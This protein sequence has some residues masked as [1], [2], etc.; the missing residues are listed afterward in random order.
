MLKIVVPPAEYWNEETEEFQYEGKETVLQLE[1]SLVSIHK[2]ESK[3]HKPFLSKNPPKTMEETID[4]VKFMTINSN[5]PDEIFMRLSNANLTQIAKYIEDPMTATWFSGK[6]KGSKRVVT[7]EIIYSQMIA[8]GIPF[9]CRKWH[10]NSLLTLIRVCNEENQ[11]K[12]KMS[13][14]ES[15]EQQAALNAMRRAKM[16]GR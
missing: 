1:H 6:N 3:Y 12:Q 7:A 2:W 5:V 4:Y 13:R 11:P 8:L 15:M 14:R 16:K 10:L 9:E